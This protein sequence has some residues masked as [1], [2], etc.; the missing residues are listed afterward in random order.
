MTREEVLAQVLR[1]NDEEY[2]SFEDSESD[3]GEEDDNNVYGYP[4]DR[5]GRVFSELSSEVERDAIRENVNNNHDSSSKELM[6]IN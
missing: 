2:S 4:N 6:Q 5:S 3:K 1:E